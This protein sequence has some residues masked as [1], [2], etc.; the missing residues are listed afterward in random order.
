MQPV[1]N[2]ALGKPEAKGFGYIFAFFG[3]ELNSFI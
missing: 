2:G 3:E 1:K